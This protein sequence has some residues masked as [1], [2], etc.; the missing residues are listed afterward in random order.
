MLM[1]GVVNCVFLLKVM[2]CLM[3]EAVDGVRLD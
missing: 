3:L 1:L 2:L